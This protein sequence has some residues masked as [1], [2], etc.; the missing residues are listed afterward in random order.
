MFLKNEDVAAAEMAP[1]LTRKTLGTGEKLMLCE[2]TFAPGGVAPEHSH[3]HEQVSYIVKGRLRFRVG[4]T[5]D[6]VGPGDSVYVASGV[7]H[8]VE[9]LEEA[10]V[11]DAF[12]P[13]RE[14]FR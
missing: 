3:P 5:E 8:R 1:G 14:D 9:A 6:V 13:P 10:V 12:S 7:P 2:V 4:D 11:V